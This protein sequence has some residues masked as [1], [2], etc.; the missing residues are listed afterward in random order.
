MDPLHQDL[1]DVAMLLTTLDPTQLA[2]ACR[3][4]GHDQPTLLLSFLRSFL[5]SVSPSHLGGLISLAQ[6]RPL[7]GAG[8]SFAAAGSSFDRG[9]GSGGSGHGDS[10]SF[11]SSSSSSSTTTSSSSASACVVGTGQMSDFGLNT[12]LGPSVGGGASPEVL[13]AEQ[14]DT[15]VTVFRLTQLREL[16]LMLLSPSQLAGMLEAV[17]KV[18]HN[19]RL[20]VLLQLQQFFAQQLPETLLAVQAEMNEFRGQP[21]Q[22]QLQQLAQRIDVTD[23][24]FALCQTLWRL[25]H[26]Y[27]K[28]LVAVAGCLPKLDQLQM[29]L[30]VRLTMLDPLDLVALRHLL[31]G[32]QTAM[33]PIGPSSRSATI[34]CASVS[35]QG[36]ACA[37]SS[38]ISEA[39]SA[40]VGAAASLQLD[41]CSSDP[42]QQELSAS[43]SSDG[44]A[45]Q[46]SLVEQPPERLVYKR[47][48]KPHPTVMLLGDAT[49]LDGNFYV[50][51][52][53]VRCDTNVILPDK[54]LGA[55]PQR[56]SP[57]RV[58]AFKKLKVLLTSHQL[59]DTMFAIRFQLRLYNDRASAGAAHKVHVWVGVTVQLLLCCV[60]GGGGLEGDD[61]GEEE[62][63]EKDRQTKK[64]SRR[65]KKKNSPHCWVGCLFFASL[66]FLF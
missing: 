26:M 6:T 65:K 33:V 61:C 44:D 31:Q 64:K 11:S 50:V 32:G 19:Q 22:L 1:I 66:C 46:L 12:L 42:L 7:R 63:E 52:V 9:G 48:V 41:L 29:Q 18:M 13:D 54:L 60:W 35:A 43:L 15:F 37:A 21:R 38:S 3:F 45:V 56:I 5:A 34:A 59:D 2:H 47:N 27:G 8:S 14:V 57:G 10:S 25:C 53:L 28:D 39:A 49:G 30:L 55:A 20:Q 16:M 24:Q 51:P 4:V 36:S 58:V 23:G 62:E 17:P 40:A